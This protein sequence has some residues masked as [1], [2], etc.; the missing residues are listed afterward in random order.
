[1]TTEYCAIECPPHY[2]LHTTCH[3]HGWKYLA[4]FEWDDDTQVLRF[5]LLA[6]NASVDVV[7]HQ[8]GRQ[9]HVEMACR[10]RQRQEARGYSL[11]AVRRA[12]GLDLDTSELL[13]VAR[14]I[15]KRYELL[16]RGGVGRM[17]RCPTLWED[18]AKTLFTT[19]CS[20]ALTEYMAASLCSIAFVATTP[21]GR[22]PFPA[23]DIL[24]RLSPEK[25]GRAAPL[26]YR[27]PYLRSLA[28]AFVR[29]PSLGQIERDGTN[30]PLA[31]AEAKKLRGFGPY[32]ANHMAVLAGH[33][34]AIPIDSEVTA[35]AQE[36]LGTAEPLRI[37][38]KYQRWGAFAWW[39]YKMDRMLRRQ[40]WLGD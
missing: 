39:G 19:N 22:F 4:P 1:M 3:T 25:L 31:Y 8:K 17:L 24:A 7:A 26:G 38:R 10:G 16:V 27:A 20:W 6:G 9:V 36:H 30:W 13:R 15:G 23:P 29:D 32:A 5:A 33:Y 12:L 14:G 2:S 40:N 28:E 34:D 37:Q 21:S 11:M 18:A 35:F